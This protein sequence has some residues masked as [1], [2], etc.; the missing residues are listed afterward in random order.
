MA[1][2]RSRKSSARRVTVD[3][4]NDVWSLLRRTV[5]RGPVDLLEVED[6]RRFSPLSVPRAASLRVPGVRIGQVKKFKSRALRPGFFFTGSRS[7]MVCVRRKERK[8][9]M[10]AKG[11]AGRRGLR[12]PKRSAF[13]SVRC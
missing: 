2:K 4:A 6:R 1:K 7:V 10:H 11:I 12:R 5:D 13:T 3:N 8:E 9:V